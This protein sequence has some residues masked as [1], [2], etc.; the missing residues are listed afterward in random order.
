MNAA[1]YLPGGS[2]GDLITL[3]GENIGPPVAA[4]LTETV[5]GYV[6]KSL[7]GFSVTVDG[8]PAAMVYAS[9]NQITVQVPYEVDTTG[10][11]SITKAIVVTN[12][13]ITAND[14]VDI[15]PTAWNIHG[16][17]LRRRPGRCA[18]PGR[19]AKSSTNSEKI[20]K[21]VVLYLTGEGLYTNT[22]ANPPGPDGSLFRQAIYRC[23]RRE[24]ARQRRCVC[25]LWRHRSALRWPPPGAPAGTAAFAVPAASI[26]YAGPFVG[27]MSDY[28]T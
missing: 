17:C 16:G 15:K 10:V 20:G 8:T 14:T 26:Q 25:R 27:G 19:N 1:S 12:G 3:F 9:Q 28:A 23:L 18:E 2:P 4:S 6:D 21:V 13:S 24:F 7:G 5:P 11:P 22:P